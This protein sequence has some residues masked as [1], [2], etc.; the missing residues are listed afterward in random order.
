[1]TRCVLTRSSPIG[2]T[3][4]SDIEEETLSEPVDEGVDN[5][6]LSF[7]LSHNQL[8][9]TMP[10]GQT[11]FI[12]T[13]LATI[14]AEEDQTSPQ[15]FTM[16]STPVSS[17]RA[18]NSSMS[19]HL[20][21]PVLSPIPQQSPGRRSENEILAPRARAMEHDTMLADMFD[22]CAAFQSPVK[23][24]GLIRVR[25]ESAKHRHSCLSRNSY[26]VAR[27]Q[28]CYHRDRR[29]NSRNSRRL[30]QLPKSS[31]M[32]AERTKAR[33]SRRLLG[34]LVLAAR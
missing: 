28:L 14:L 6:T 23:V 25:S 29:C 26:R 8:A 24:S 19:V 13:N 5:R 34:P 31:R 33:A 32:H 15:P 12:F 16:H 22:R 10:F 4:Y 7:T 20:S 9:N 17:N 1:M 30:V 18:T 11:D 21:S 2:T 3:A 27:C